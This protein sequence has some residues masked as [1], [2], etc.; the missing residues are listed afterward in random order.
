MTKISIKEV[1]KKF[2]VVVDGHADFKNYGKD[3]VCAAISTALTMTINALDNLGY[4]IIG[5][6]MSEGYST[7]TVESNDTVCAIIKTFKEFAVQMS[8]DHP[9]NVKIF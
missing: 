1:D 6:E 3:I 5:L 9:K 7:F 4:N 8:E 2:N